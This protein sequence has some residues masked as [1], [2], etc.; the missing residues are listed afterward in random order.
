MMHPNEI[1]D[2][3]CGVFHVSREDLLSDK[4]QRMVS[5]PRKIAAYLIHNRSFLGYK[6]IAEMFNRKDHTTCMYW[7]KTVKLDIENRPWIA[8]LVSEVEQTLGPIAAEPDPE[9]TPAP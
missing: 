7:V 5:E 6:Q 1:V 8:Q 3:V 9:P 4:R 2:A